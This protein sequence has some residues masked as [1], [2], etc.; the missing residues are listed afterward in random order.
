M[1][2]DV[3]IIGAGP[4]GTAAAHRL[5]THGLDVLLVDRTAFPR[6][7]PCAG[8]LT[9]K[10]LA[11]LPYSIASVLQRST[12]DMTIGLRTG[13]GEFESQFS[14]GETICT[15][16]VRQA[17]DQFNFEEA[18]SIGVDFRIA[19]AISGISMD[20]GGVTVHADGKTIHARYLIGA[21]GANSIVRRLCKTEMPFFRGFAL[22]GIVP[23]APSIPAPRAEIYFG[24][25]D[26]GYGWLFPKGDHFNVG[27]YTCDANVSLSK[28]RLRSYSY[29]RLGTE[30]IKHM[31]GYPIGFGGDRYRPSSGQVVL[32]GDAGGFAEPL[33]GEGLHNALKTGQEAAQAIVDIEATGL[34]PRSLAVHFDKRIGHIR[35][36]VRRCRRIAF[37]LF[38]PNLV[39]AGRRALDLPIAKPALLNGF[40]AGK[41]MREIT[42]TFLWS[43][44][45]KPARPQSLVEFEEQPHELAA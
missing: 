32:V 10:S 17:F 41:T 9:L 33:L 40:A 1:D 45:Y 24:V 20:E 31:V 16:A 14:N 12:S 4:A 27:I 26:H 11:L 15:F 44:L 28:S 13:N 18:T 19:K 7:K 5:A 2:Y 38:Y 34:P 39:R 8:G 3:V 35:T 36:D 30:R 22:E 25:V 23:Y 42:N 29:E 37:R 21:D 6:P 43:A